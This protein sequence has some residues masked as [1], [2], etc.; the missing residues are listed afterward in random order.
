MS[1]NKKPH[2]YLWNSSEICSHSF[3][4]LSQC[5]ARIEAMDCPGARPHQISLSFRADIHLNPPK[6]MVLLNTRHLAH[7]W[8]HQVTPDSPHLVPP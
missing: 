2:D 7:E 3:H 8:S 6:L 5:G 1:Q 4:G